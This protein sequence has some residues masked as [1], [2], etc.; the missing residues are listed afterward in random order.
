VYAGTTFTFNYPA[1][2]VP[3]YGE[4]HH[5]AVCRQGKYLRVFLDGVQITPPQEISD[6]YSYNG[7]W[8][9]L[10]LGSNLTSVTSNP[11]MGILDNF[12]I[13]KGVARWVDDFDPPEYEYQSSG[14]YDIFFDM[15]GEEHKEYNWMARGA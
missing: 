14:E 4:R 10:A 6:A 9:G 7:M 3:D 15:V 8:R 1:S 12:R 13:T 11:C 2:V 5:Y